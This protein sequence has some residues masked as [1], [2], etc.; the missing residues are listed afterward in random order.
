MPAYNTIQRNFISSPRAMSMAK[1]FMNSIQ[2]QNQQNR[3]KM[4]A[5]TQIA[6][7]EPS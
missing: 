2:S 5:N 6:S 4:Y 3:D 7:K 1:I